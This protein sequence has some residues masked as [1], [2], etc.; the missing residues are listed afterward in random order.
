MELTYV[1]L[2]PLKVGDTKRQ[3]GEL[4]PEAKT[5]RNVHAWIGRGYL[6]PIPESSVAGGVDDQ[7]TDSAPEAG[8]LPSPDERNRKDKPMKINDVK[9]K[10]VAGEI[11]AEDALAEEMERDNPR[12]TL[13]EWLNTAMKDEAQGKEGDEL[14]GANDEIVD[15]PGGDPDDPD[16][17]AAEEEEDK[18]LLD[19]LRDRLPG[20]DNDDDEDNEEE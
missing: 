15:P 13:V 11:S 4:V 16:S 3:P 5:W 7:S 10:V 14:T 9:D 8:D 2:K 12:T 6:A 19:K 18:S 17:E 1:A 20:S